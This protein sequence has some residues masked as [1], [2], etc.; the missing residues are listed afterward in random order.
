M[1]T[2]HTPVG[3]G[4]LVI[5]NRAHSRVVEAHVQALLSAFRDNGL[6]G[7]QIPIELIG[8]ACLHGSSTSHIH[9]PAWGPGTMHALGI[10]V[11]RH[12]QNGQ[13]GL[14]ELRSNPVLLPRQQGRHRWKLG[15]EARRPLRHL[16]AFKDLHQS[17]LHRHSR[18]KQRQQ[19]NHCATHG[20]HLEAPIVPPE[21]ML[22]TG[23]IRKAAQECGVAPKHGRSHQPE[24]G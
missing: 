13:P 19:S 24:S 1:L 4:I 14:G 7:E 18:R 10:G 20:N 6:G 12:H 2:P 16:H 21:P 23:A 11:T 3:T 17:R 15:H 22:C 5:A 9:S 8:D